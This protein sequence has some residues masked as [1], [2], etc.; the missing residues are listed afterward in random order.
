MIIRCP[1]CGEEL[2]LEKEPA[3]EQLFFRLGW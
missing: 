1:L 3:E 2:E